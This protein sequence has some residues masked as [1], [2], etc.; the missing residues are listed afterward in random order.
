MVFHLSSTKNSSN[1]FVFEREKYDGYSPQ[2]MKEHLKLVVMDIQNKT[3]LFSKLNELSYYVVVDDDTNEIFFLSGRELVHFSVE[4]PDVESLR[5]K[6]LSEGIPRS[7]RFAVSQAVELEYAES[8]ESAYELIKWYAYALARLHEVSSLSR[9]KINIL[10]DKE[11]RSMEYD[12]SKLIVA[13][14]SKD[15]AM[16]AYSI[17]LHQSKIRVLMAAL[18]HIP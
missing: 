8:L 14:T 17:L 5:K 10:F 3:P 15:T 18:Q 6:V 7:D 12:R 4:V 13:R 1:A 11:C 16:L 9:E 2:E